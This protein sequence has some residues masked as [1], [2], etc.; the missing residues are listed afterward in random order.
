MKDTENS[1]LSM[2][3][4]DCQT[5]SPRD[6]HKILYALKGIGNLGQPTKAIPLIMDCV[7]NAKHVNMSIA[8]IQAMRKMSLL[9][10]VQYELMEILADQ[11]SDLEKRL[12][13][14][15]LL[16]SKP[17]KEHVILARDVANDEK[18]STQLRSFINSYLKSA[19]GNKA[20][21][22]KG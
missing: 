8:A 5:S 13:V 10:D 17:T 4:N 21:A 15:L 6:Q 14:F 22:H 11:N 19:V 20:P 3:G 7:Q 2:L 1:L 12:Q 9:T 18:D 16:M